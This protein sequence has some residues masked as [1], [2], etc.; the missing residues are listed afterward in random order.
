MIRIENVSKVFNAGNVDEVSALKNAS[1]EIE[2]GSF[3]VIV[4]SNGSGKSTLLNL[5]L[6]S[7]F[8]T[9]G[10]IFINENNI[11][12]LPGYERSKWIS[13]VF[14]NPANGTAPDLSILE[15]F[16][17]AALRSSNK[18]LKIGIDNNF[19]ELVREKIKKLDMGLEDKLNQPMGNLSGGQ[20][21]ALTLLMGVMDKTD[22]LLMDEPTAALDPK[23]AQKIMQLANE[24]N[25]TL[26]ITIVLITHSL[27]D[28][29]HYGN[30][31]L[32]FKSGVI[33]K[34][35]NETEKQRL[36]LNEMYDWFL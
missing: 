7:F 2:A 23:S 27:K 34:D 25:A 1:L 15:N 13:M 14:Q 5:I 32:M 17:L 26:G 18:T 20:R 8:S 36:T 22:V 19:V 16:R 35:F 31:L 6:G 10:K 4:G 11:T 12:Q 21:Q 9:S 24:I 30:R 33:E 28:A 29:L 3:V